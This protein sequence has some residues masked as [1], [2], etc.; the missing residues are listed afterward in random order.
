FPSIFLIA[1]VDVLIGWFVLRYTVFVRFVFAIGTNEEAVRLS[2]HEQKRYK[3]AVFSISGLT[4]GIA[5][6]VYLLRLNVGSQ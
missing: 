3:I 2:G 4:A 5:A 1:I 6:I